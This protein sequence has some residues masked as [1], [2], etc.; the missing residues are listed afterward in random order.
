MR[1]LAPELDGFPTSLEERARWDAPQVRKF[2]K[3]LAPYVFVNGALL[4]VNLFGGHVSIG[5]TAIWTVFV[6][7][8]YAKLWSDGYDWHDV[9]RQ[10]KDRMFGEVISDLV[11]SVHSTF[12]RQKREELRAQGRLHTNAMRGVLAPLGPTPSDGSPAA[13]KRNLS[14]GMIAK[15]G[16]GGSAAARGPQP[17]APARAEDLGRYADVVRR[18]REDREEVARLLGTIPPAERGNIPDVAGTAIEL[19]NRVEMMAVELAR[20]TDALG[21]QNTAAI[22]KEISALEAEANP[23]DTSKS[24]ARVRRL[25]Q[26]RRDRRAVVE[27]DRKRETREAQIESCRIALENMRLDLVRLRTGNSSVQSVTHI[28]EQAMAL[29]RDVDIA[30]GAAGEVRDATRVRS[31][32]PA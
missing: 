22:D 19:V 9:M 6:A 16:R 26:L 30:V 11:D 13:A 4:V 25:A 17:L 1:P 29:A 5:I 18:V 2:R 14:V 21:P 28:A 32:S 8:R 15:L 20:S 24:E 31:A 27:V 12:S 10:P 7:W 23:L 3:T